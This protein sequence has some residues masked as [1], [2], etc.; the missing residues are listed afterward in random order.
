MQVVV[1]A[2]YRLWD[3]EVE[4]DSEETYRHGQNAE[5]AILADGKC[6]RIQDG[7]SGI[8]RAGKRIDRAVEANRYEAPPRCEEFLEG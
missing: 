8:R 6:R 3:A 1:V 4:N 5:L 2:K 7:E